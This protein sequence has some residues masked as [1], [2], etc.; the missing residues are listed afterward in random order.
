[1]LSRRSWRRLGS[2]WP[3]STWRHARTKRK[4]RVRPRIFDKWLAR[5]AELCVQA[6]DE[7]VGR[8]LDRLVFGRFA[9]NDSRDMTIDF[10]EETNQRWTTNAFAKNTC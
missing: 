8:E 7:A 5:L 2:G 1:M 6:D 3:S 4:L 9:I 10:P